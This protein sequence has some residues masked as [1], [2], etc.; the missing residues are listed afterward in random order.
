MTIIND[1]GTALLW[2]IRI[3][4]GVRVLVLL[5]KIMY[6]EPSENTYKNR[7]KKM[8]AFYILAESIY[9]I[10]AIIRRYFVPSSGNGHEIIQLI[11][12]ILS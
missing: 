9:Y 11:N 4:V 10:A 6:E 3:G 7:L 5:I 2:L 1:M 12:N 8:V